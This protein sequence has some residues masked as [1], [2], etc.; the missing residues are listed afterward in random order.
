[1]DKKILR[2]PAVREQ[3][4]QKDARVQRFRQRVEKQDKEIQ[5]LRDRLAERALDRRPGQMKPENVVWMFGTGR[6][7]STWLSNMMDDLPGHTV[8]REPLVGALFGYLYYVR[9]DH[10]RVGGN[11]HYIMSS[12]YKDTWLGPIR[13]MVLGGGAARFP[14]VADGGYL[15]IKE[16]NGSMGAPL[17]MQAL[18]ESR[19]IFLVR[20]PRDVI[21]SDLDARK[22][23]S[24]LNQRRDKSRSRVANQDPDRFVKG[25]A[26]NYLRDAGNSRLAYEEHEGYKTLVR[27]EDL[28]SDTLGTMR[29][30]YSELGIEVSD[31][32][33][34]RVVQKHAWE[35]I[36][37]EEKGQGKFYRKASPG[38]WRDDLTPEQVGV[39]EEIT[40]PLLNQFYPG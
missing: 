20:D 18:P 13:D 35:N 22:E 3:I 25:R 30:I 8:W 27:Y 17:M 1:M 2:D 5:R 38:G 9:A 33:L 24:W 7:G 37:E 4:A 19:M 34:S 32:E 39:I 16:P 21:A 26:Q 36:P 15:V 29:R 6:S 14:E 12:L 28:L 23:G 40:A 10:R 31:S 11:K